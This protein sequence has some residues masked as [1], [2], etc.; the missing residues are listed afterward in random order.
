MK[1]ETSSGSG[2]LIH[3]SPF[4]TPYP[5]SMS[6]RGFT[7][8]EFLLV[9]AI[10]LVIGGMV[11]AFSN[12][13][14]LQNSVAETADRLAF[15]LRNAQG[16]AL[17][18]KGGDSWGVAIDGTDIVVFQGSS[19]ALRDVG[20]ERRTAIPSSVSIAG[21]SETIFAS[22]TGIPSASGSVSIT[23]SGGVERRVVWNELGILD[24]E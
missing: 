23:S 7:L 1:N 19:F 3:H 13:F 2:C 6:S 14:L 22:S 18:G 5:P 20:S 11:P 10:L 17:S 4:S 15:S 8:I 12:R 21:F 24:R 9:A 16:Y